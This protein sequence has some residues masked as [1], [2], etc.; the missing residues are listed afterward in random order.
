MKATTANLQQLEAMR[1]NCTEKVNDSSL[2]TLDS[3]LSTKRVY[4]A[5][6]KI[7]RAIARWADSHPRTVN[8]LL[9]IEALGAIYIIF[10]YV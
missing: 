5:E 8:A 2:F 9:T 7:Y 10:M 4:R 3:S 6:L 1:L